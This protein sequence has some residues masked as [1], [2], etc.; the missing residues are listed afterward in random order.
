[1]LINLKDEIY[2]LKHRWN[3]M[4][5][6]LQKLIDYKKQ[7]TLLLNEINLKK[8]KKKELIENIENDFE[9]SQVLSSIKPVSERVFNLLT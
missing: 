8:C 6:S 5:T 2:I 7:H 1:M 9:L 3:T 4:K